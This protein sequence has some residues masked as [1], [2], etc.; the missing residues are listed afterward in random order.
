MKKKLSVL[1]LILLGLGQLK[2]QETAT[3]YIINPSGLI[4]GESIIELKIND[5]SHGIIAPKSY[6]SMDVP[7]GFVNIIANCTVPVYDINFGS[8]INKSYSNSMS[9]EYKGTRQVVSQ[10]SL[11]AKA[12][13]KYYIKITENPFSPSPLLKVL[14]AKD[15]AKIEKK[16]DKNISF[17]GEYSAIPKD[18]VSTSNSKVAAKNT[19]KSDVDKNIP[20][21][22]KS[23]DDTYVLIIA[24]EDYQFVDPVNF[25]S[26][27]GEVFKEYCI[28]T[29]G[30][31]EKKIRYYP[32]AS[33]GILSGG[34][35]WLKNVLDNFENSKAIVYYCGHGIPDEK[36]GDAY[37]IPVDGTGTNTTTCYSL[38]NLYKTLSSTKAS[39]VTYFMDACF[40]GA[41]K[42]G[43]MLVA[44]RGV[45]R[46]AKKETLAGNTIVFSA[47]SGDETAMTYAE[48]GHGLFTYFL[49]K[50]LQETEGDVSYQDLAEYINKNV[51]KEAI[52]INEKPQTPIVATSNSVTSSWKTMRFE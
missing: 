10:T 37:I 35:D 29:L 17:A 8:N 24:N 44:A 20:T 50:K 4:L 39:R 13:E 46:E 31:P 33:Y 23:T 34:I 42:E 15:I 12:N 45:A 32:N 28:N 25:A 36:T 21:T 26:H 38:N 3:I 1:L 7:V 9:S 22:N 48:K 49:L 19:P 51:K 40:T 52:L 14:E 2:A 18:E 47:S 6:I 5:M 16:L 30:I 43:S 27:D 11:Q 41:N